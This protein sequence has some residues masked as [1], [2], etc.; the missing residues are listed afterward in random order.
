M[1]IVR[2]QGPEESLIHVYY[3]VD[4]SQPP[5]GSG[6]MGKVL[7]GVRVNQITGARESVAVKFLYDD[8]PESAIERSRREASI[9][10]DSENLVK[11]YGFIQ[12]DETLQDGSVRHH[13]HVVSELLDG[14]RLADLMGGKVTDSS[15][16]AS[17][18]LEDLYLLYKQKPLA[19]ATYV[20]KKILSGLMAM[21][22]NGYIH[23]DVD[24]ANIIVLSDGRIKL[25]DFGIARL[26][27]STEAIFP[28]VTSVGQFVGKPGYAAPEL[29]LGDIAHQDFTTDIYA[30]GIL[31]FQLIT[32]HLPFT[33]TM[34]EVLQ[35]Q[36]KT[37]LPVKE[38]PPGPFR[39]IIKKATEKKQLDRFSTCAQFRSQ[40]EQ[41]ERISKNDGHSPVNLAEKKIPKINWKGMVVAAAVTGLIA[42]SAAGAYTLSHR[43]NQGGDPIKEVEKEE[44]EKEVIINSSDASLENS[45]AWF[46]NLS[47]QLLKDSTRVIEAKLMLEKVAATDYASA[48]EACAL[49]ASL[50]SHSGE[51]E[52]LGIDSPLPVDYL[53]ARELNLKAIHLDETCYQALYELAKDCFDDARNVSKRDTDAALLYF[54]LCR[55]YAE[56]RGDSEF[57]RLVVEMTE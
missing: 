4:T 14:V 38:I 53:K 50:Y 17:K 32:G 49:L 7:K 39:K 57:V 51:V 44:E 55:M 13:Y 33:G 31:M 23:R 12:T 16:A 35:M 1:A 47:K 29:V 25:I 41:A 22:D 34:E 45:A 28:Q 48:A 42:V 36:Q 11:T 56:Q 2:L 26:I 15:G 37:P 6:G 5:V 3:E 27:N 10:I 30:V 21:H 54:K 24:P 18:S 52:V 9:R 19:F 40:I 8:L 43:R 20:T 46:I